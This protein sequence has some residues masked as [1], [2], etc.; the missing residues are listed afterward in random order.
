MN[1]QRSSWSIVFLVILPL[2]VQA[3]AGA[4]QP[5]PAAD[6]GTVKIG[7]LPLL[8]YAP[9]Y[10]GYEKGLFEEEGL[11]VELQV[12]NS[13]SIM[14]APLTT[15][16]LDVG[17]GEAGSALF[18]AIGQGLEIKVVAGQ[19][20]MRPGEAGI[21]L[22][23]R[24]D[25]YDSGE[26]RSPADLKG[27]RIAM[28]I[29]RGQSEYLL[30]EVMGLA[31]L[32]IEDVT[33]VTLPFPDMPAALANGAID[34]AIISFPT[35]AKALQDG[36]AVIFLEGNEIVEKHQTSILYFGKRLLEPENRQAAVRFLVAYLKSVRQLYGDGWTG[37]ENLEIIQRYTNVPIDVIKTSVRS[38]TDLNGELNWASVERMQAY[39]LSRGYLEID[40]PLNRDQVVEDGLLQEALETLGR[41]EK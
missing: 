35:A 12:F 17:M 8:G 28:N 19:S 26:I 16:Q 38:Y 3:C 34:G 24:K 37:E 7:Y 15:G 30:A 31:G 4:G 20:Q 21:P 41:F 27:R 1:R 36:S 25:L 2:M 33:L 14:I 9:F 18:N 11:K 10:I 23:I 39:Y 6:L 40:Q 5:D 29:E 13:G 22:L 32:T